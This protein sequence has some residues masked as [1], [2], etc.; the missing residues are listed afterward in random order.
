MPESIPQF[1]GL[2]LETKQRQ[3]ALARRLVKHS[4]LE[5]ERLAPLHW[6][7]VIRLIPNLITQPVRLQIVPYRSTIHHKQ[8]ITYGRTAR[9]VDISQLMISTEVLYDQWSIL[10]L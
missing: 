9:L 5:D 10:M 2:H 7:S 1:G 4:Q 3:T 6:G 8:Q